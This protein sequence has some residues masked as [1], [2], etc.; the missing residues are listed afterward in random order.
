MSVTRKYHY[1]PL[2]TNP[3]H[4]NEEPQNIIKKTKGY[5][6]KQSYI[7]QNLKTASMCPK[8]KIKVFVM[9]MAFIPSHKAKKMYTIF[10]S[11]LR[12]SFIR[13]NGCNMHSKILN[14]LYSF[15][16]H[17]S[18]TIVVCTRLHSIM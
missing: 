17:I 18:K 6:A 8:T 12:H 15:L 13:R 14:I 2:Q 3:W 7:L 16:A 4:R 11:W 9:N 10:H 1:Q 5:S